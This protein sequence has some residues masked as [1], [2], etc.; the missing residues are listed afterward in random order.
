ME[1]CRG[2][3]DDFMSTT[4]DTQ[5]IEYIKQVGRGLL[6]LHSFNLIH[7]DIAARNIL[8]CGGGSTAEATAKITDFGL[9]RCKEVINYS[10]KDTILPPYYKKLLTL[11]GK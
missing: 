2:S 8:L 5:L 3:L 11:G 4:E 1:K 9:T 6:Y 10:D 7:G